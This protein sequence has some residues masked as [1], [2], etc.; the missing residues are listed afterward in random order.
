MPIAVKTGIV[1]VTQLIKH[2][3][4]VLTTYRPAIDRVIAAAVAGGLITSVQ[5][6]VLETWL[7]GAQT[8]CDI[9]RIVS[10]Y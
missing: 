1:V 5:K 4:R 10:G 8:A 9:I 6:D 7:N 3:C 2:M